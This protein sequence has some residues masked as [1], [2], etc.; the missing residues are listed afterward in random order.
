MGKPRANEQEL[1]ARPTRSGEL[2][3]HSEAVRFNPG[4]KCSGCVAEDRVLTW[5]DLSGMAPRLGG[6]RLVQQWAE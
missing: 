2:A 3:Q 6:E 5:G 4:G 1:H